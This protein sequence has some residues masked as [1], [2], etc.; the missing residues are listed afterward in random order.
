MIKPRARYRHA[1]DLWHVSVQLPSKLSKSGVNVS[2]WGPTLESA[3]K[4]LEQDIL[5]MEDHIEHL[6]AISDALDKEFKFSWRDLLK[7]VMFWRK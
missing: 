3:Y 1:W 2:A 4:A 6:E 5:L 7:R